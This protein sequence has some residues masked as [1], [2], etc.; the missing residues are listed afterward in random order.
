VH[1]IES[2]H[3]GEPEAGQH[4][5]ASQHP[6]KSQRQHSEQHQHILTP[7]LPQQGGDISL[8]YS[9][10]RMGVTLENLL[11]DKRFL[12]TAVNIYTLELVLSNEMFLVNTSREE[13]SG[14]TR[15]QQL[16]LNAI[17]RAAI[18]LCYS[19]ECRGDR[20]RSTH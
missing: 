2:G 15:N 10:S 7:G 9:Q 5:R 19:R 12:P 6:G 16:G 3:E 18:R 11:N 13:G 8:P 17:D 1:Q 20:Q 14:A 4:H